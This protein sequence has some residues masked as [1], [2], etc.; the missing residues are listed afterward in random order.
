MDEYA[1]PM[2]M[3]GCMCSI[4]LE[5][6]KQMAEAQRKMSRLD[7]EVESDPFEQSM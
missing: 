7:V 3:Y 1:S 5:S 6:V 2:Y 4:E